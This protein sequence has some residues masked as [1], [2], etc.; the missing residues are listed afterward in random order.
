MISIYCSICKRTIVALATSCQG[1]LRLHPLHLRSASSRLTRSSLF[2]APPVQRM[3]SRHQCNQN[4]AASESNMLLGHHVIVIVTHNVVRPPTQSARH[5]IANIVPPS[6]DRTRRPKQTYKATPSSQTL[7]SGHS[8]KDH[9]QQ[10]T[11]NKQDATAAAPNLLSA[12]TAQNTK[13]SGDKNQTNRDRR[14]SLPFYLEHSTDTNHEV[15]KHD[16][17]RKDTTIPLRR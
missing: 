15:R 1:G 5:T 8:L 9:N 16:K 11:K 2:I 14:S 4:H 6:R 3:P 7:T 12:S 10:V 13:S 17:N